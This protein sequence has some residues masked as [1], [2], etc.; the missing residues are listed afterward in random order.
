MTPSEEASYYALRAVL[1]HE[2]A[3]ML[4]EE[5]QQLTKLSKEIVRQ[6]V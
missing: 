3:A 5:A 6:A 1:L 2:Q 4:L